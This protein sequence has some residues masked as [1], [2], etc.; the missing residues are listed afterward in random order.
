MSTLLNSLD[1]NQRVQL[2]KFIGRVAESKVMNEIDK[3]IFASETCFARYLVANDFNADQAFAQFK[4]HLEWRRQNNINSLVDS[5]E[6]R[7]SQIRK[8]LPNCFHYQD[9]QG[10]PLWII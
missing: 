4:N 5:E 6:I 8:Y 2:T 3:M 7:E 9:S 10:R 1:K